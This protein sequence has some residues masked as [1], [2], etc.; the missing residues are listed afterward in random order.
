MAEIT[1][2]KSEQ[3]RG[4]RRGVKK[5]LQPD[6][7]AMVDLAF[8]LLT[9]FVMTTHMK[10]ED[11]MMVIELPDSKGGTA[12]INSEKMLTL[13]PAENNRLFY[14]WGLGEEGIHPLTYSPEGLRQLI[15]SHVNHEGISRCKGKEAQNCWDPIIVIKARKQARYKNLMDVLDEMKISGVP[16]YAVADFSQNDSIIWLASNL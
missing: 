2:N 6:L 1:E 11:T 14:Y 9:F 5:R 7:T 15:R 8:L 3:P 13:I 4:H 10:K 12:K 16:K